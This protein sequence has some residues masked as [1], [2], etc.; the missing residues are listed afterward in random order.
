MF[1]IDLSTFPSFLTTRAL[2]E[3]VY[4]QAAS[5]LV[6]GIN[7]EETIQQILDMGGGTWERDTVVRALRA[8]FNNPERAVEYLYSVWLF[9][10]IYIIIT[11]LWLSNAF[12]SWVKN[13]REFLNKLMWHQWHE[14]H[15]LLLQQLHRQLLQRL[16]CLQQL[17]RH[18]VGQ[19]QTLWICSP[20]SFTIFI[21]IIISIDHG[22]EAS[23]SSAYIMICCS[24]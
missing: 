3:D 19:M 5:N 1:I 4:G 6:A 9:Y 11:I 13:H 2:T 16:L 23:I 15:Q 22:I 18:P 21:I 7:L 10:P 8:A 24:D 20:R 12:I 14:H 17:L